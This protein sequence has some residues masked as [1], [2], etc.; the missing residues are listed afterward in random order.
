MSQIAAAIVGRI[1]PQDLKKQEQVFALARYWYKE[2]EM[3]HAK[4]QRKTKKV[5]NKFIDA[6]SNGVDRAADPNVYGYGGGDLG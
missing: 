6:R 1:K 4:T 2:A 5:P 3:L